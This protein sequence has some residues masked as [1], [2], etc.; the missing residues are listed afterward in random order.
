MRETDT[1]L[2]MKTPTGEV[3]EL[4]KS[5]I[6]SQTPS[7]SS[8]PQM[9]LILSKQDLRDLMAYLLELDGRE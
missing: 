8:M 4:K 5:E 3:E 6:A 7:V 9:H 1:V 2:F